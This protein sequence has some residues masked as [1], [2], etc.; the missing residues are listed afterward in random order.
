MDTS[1]GSPSPGFLPGTSL[2]PAEA[3]STSW[4]TWNTPW[5]WDLLK[6]PHG[7]EFGNLRFVSPLWDILPS[8]FG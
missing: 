7:L 2:L 1:S 5:P 4:D 6:D 3:T 8:T